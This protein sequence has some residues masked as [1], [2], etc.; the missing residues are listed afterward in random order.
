[1][2]RRRGGDR[3]RGLEADSP[4]E[5][6]ARGWREVLG[7][8][9]EEVG[10][11]NVSIVAAGVAFYMMLSLFPALVA[12]VAIYGIVADPAQVQ[13]VIGR[14]EGVLP[15]SALDLV[16]SQL[17]GIVQSAPTTLGWG[18]ALSILVALWS[19]AK[20]AKSLIAGVNLVYDEEEHRGFLRLQG[21]ALLF[22]VGMVLVGL[23][24][25]ALITV[26][27]NLAD[28]LGAAGAVAAMV[29]QWVLLLVLILAGLAV[30]YRFAPDRDDPRWRWVTPGSVTAALLWLVAS[31][32]F[33]WYAANFGSFN[34]T[35][36]A[37]AGV[38]VLL[39]WL[40]I[41]FFL[42]LLGGELNS[43]LE[44]QTRRDTTRGRPEPMG[45]RGAV[46]ADTSPEG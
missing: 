29:A 40:Q 4:R 31:A 27:P 11:D 28:M 7:R 3:R 16:E 10:R 21:L 20:G 45:R 14:L 9:K 26:V 37:L 39:L 36:G 12:A 24:A 35:Y 42:I 43:E 19:A 41:T 5:V 6:P 17:R 23:V 1:M 8:V 22:T 46:K 25:V 34:E 44:Q 30:T 2:A 33:S 38:V 18:A 32:L 15:A 13:S